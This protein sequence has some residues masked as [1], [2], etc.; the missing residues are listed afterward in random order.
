MTLTW[1]IG[2]GGLIVDFFAHRGAGSVKKR[3]DARMMTS[4]R[5]SPRTGFTLIEMLLVLVVVSIMASLL[6]A[7]ISDNPLRQLDREARRLQAVLAMASDEALMQ[8]LEISLAVT[9]SAEGV[10][11]YQFLL[12]DPENMSWEASDEKPYRFHPLSSSVSMDVTA[13]DALSPSTQFDQRTEQLQRLSSDNRWR[14]GVLLLSSGET[15]PF[16]ITLKHGEA[17]GSVSVSSD[18]F[19]GINIQ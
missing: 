11:G 17:E 5:W 9:E 15:T 12:L 7:S 8:G 1:A 10:A 2:S 13:T 16:L 18:G 19:S 3:G 4:W 14:P 6:V